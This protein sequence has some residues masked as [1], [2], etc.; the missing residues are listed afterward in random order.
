VRMLRNH[1]VKGGG[2]GGAGAGAGC[3]QLRFSSGNTGAILLGCSGSNW[4]LWH[5]ACYSC[6][7]KQSLSELGACVFAAA[8]VL[9][10]STF[11]AGDTQAGTC[12]SLDSCN[13]CG[14]WDLPSRY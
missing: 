8:I 1:C 13:P 5:R 14:V 4:V 7:C 2:S 10:T 9:C 12:S 3:L 6:L 11:C